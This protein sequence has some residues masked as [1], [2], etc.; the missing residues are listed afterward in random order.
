MP[1]EVTCCRCRQPLESPG[2]LLFGTPGPLGQTQKLHLCTACYLLTLNWLQI[3]ENIK[4]HEVR[5]LTTI[6]EWSST[7]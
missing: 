2:A 4:Q 5:R 7:G 6:G 1:F 3:P